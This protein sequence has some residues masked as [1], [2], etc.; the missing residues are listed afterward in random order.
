MN[1]DSYFGQSNLPHQKR[2]QISPLYIKTETGHK[3]LPNKADKQ[4][5]IP[6]PVSQRPGYSHLPHPGSHLPTPGSKEV[7]QV[8]FRKKV[9]Y[10]GIKDGQ[11]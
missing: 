3:I 5:N 2:D 6:V 8:A 10:L 4:L 11:F 9:A 1:I 7:F